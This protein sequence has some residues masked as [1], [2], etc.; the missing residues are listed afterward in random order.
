MRRIRSVFDC[1]RIRP[2]W[3]FLVSPAR[4]RG[5]GG[6]M[7]GGKTRCLCEAAFQSA[8]DHPGIIILVARN[9]HTA[10]VQTTKRT[11]MKEVIPQSLIL[12]SKASQGEDYVL[13]S[14]TSQ[15]HFVGMDNPQRWFSAEIGDLYFD[16]AHEIPEDK[17]VLLATRLR[18]RCRECSRQGNV[19]CPHLPHRISLAF[20][21]DN[22]S[23]WL[24]RWFI[25]DAEE[26][27]Y[28][29]GRHKGFRK[30]DLR[31]GE[32][33]ASLGDCEFI[34]SRAIDNPYLPPGYVETTLSALP[35][36]LR[37]RYLEGRWVYTSGRGFF[38]A[39]ALGFYE[40]NMAKPPQ[41]RGELQEKDGRAYLRPSRGGSFYCWAPPE[42]DRRY[43]V[44][45]DA[46]S[47]GAAD[48][49]ALVVLDA[50]NLEQVAELQEKIEP[51]RLARQAEL[52][53]RIYN[54]AIIVP[55]IT[56]GWG[57][58]VVQELRRLGYG[59][60]YT[61]PVID[62]LS[63]SWTDRLGWDTNEKTR[64]YMLDTLDRLIRH[65]EVIIRSHRL[66]S[67][68][69]SFIWPS[70][71]G[72]TQKPPRAQEGASDDLVIACA[73]ACAVALERRPREERLPVL[74]YTSDSD[75]IIREMLS[76]DRLAVST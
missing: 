43:I 40:Q 50:Q 23:H 53:A 6:A 5:Y 59:R 29:D 44:A 10:I 68:L 62:R 1:S 54:H 18:Q 11:M 71:R 34:I 69:A 14:N 56:G 20:N 15:I 13:L 75:R 2:Q 67:Q 38:D 51:A 42:K 30:P 47:G 37:E 9:E 55:E 25:A 58:A 60:I 76:S 65:H 17:V 16:E 57:F 61:R 33:E 24:F 19:A 39:E 72:L 45:C 28:P 52:A 66:L 35:R 46:S 32:G 36:V 70:S 49:S 73:I 64:A 74:T 22:P 21:P 31:V 7:G 63:R 3:A 41:V 4:V 48:Y 12:A 27:R 8:L 26:T